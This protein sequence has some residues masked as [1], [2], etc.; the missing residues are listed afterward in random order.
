KPA[1]PSRRPHDRRRRRGWP[2]RLSGAAGLRH[3]DREDL[4]PAAGS[5]A[6]PWAT[7]PR[8]ARAEPPGLRPHRRRG[9]LAPSAANAAVALRPPSESAAVARPR[10][11]SVRARG[12]GTRRGGTRARCAHR[13]LSQ[14]SPPRRAALHARKRLRTRR[15]ARTCGQTRSVSLSLAWPL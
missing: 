7:L 9:D 4:P 10:L 6:S 3:A 14:D 5:T 1:V 12:A 13:L 11:P 2:P 15:R 8:L